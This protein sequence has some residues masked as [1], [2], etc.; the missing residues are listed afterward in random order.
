MLFRSMAESK[1]PAGSPPNS[2]PPAPVGPDGKILINSLLK[3]L[4]PADTQPVVSADEI[5]EAIGH[6]FDDKLSPVQTGA[7]LTCLNFTGRDRHADV[8]AKCADAMRK[9]AS[10]IDFQELEEVVKR[11]GKAEGNYKGG[12]VCIT[13]GVGLICYYHNPSIRIHHSNSDSKI[14]TS[15]STIQSHT[16]TPPV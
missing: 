5:A 14:V 12:L 1:S 2:P 4:W 7:L 16:N 3:R 6:I 9:A 15:K 8:I 11:K 10:P 13:R